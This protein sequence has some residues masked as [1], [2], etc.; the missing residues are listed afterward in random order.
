MEQNRSDVFV[1]C[2]SCGEVYTITTSEI[3]WWHG[4]N[5][6]LPKRCRVYGEKAKRLKQGVRNG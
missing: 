5:L 3:E 6:H 2:V 4:R 1:R